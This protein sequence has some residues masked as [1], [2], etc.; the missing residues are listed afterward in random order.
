MGF[1]FQ[2]LSRISTRE[3]RALTRK[4]GV[5]GHGTVR[6]P[7]RTLWLR[8]TL[9]LPQGNSSKMTN[10]GRELR[11]AEINENLLVRGSLFT[12]SAPSLMVS[13]HRLHLQG[14][15]VSSPLSHTLV[16]A[17]LLRPIQESHRKKLPFAWHDQCLGLG[18]LWK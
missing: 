3:S 12:T 6:M 4:C 15:V 11:T 16:L 14:Q 13:M 8:G 18:S 7:R 9:T 2:K 10:S 1:L 17:S 5:P